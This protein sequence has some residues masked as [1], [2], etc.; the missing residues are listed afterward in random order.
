VIAP[1]AVVPGGRGNT[2]FAPRV[3]SACLSPA[4]SLFDLAYATLRAN[5]VGA[6]AEENPFVLSLSKRETPTP[7]KHLHPQLA[8]EFLGLRFFPC[9][10]RAQCQPHRLYWRLRYLNS[11]NLSPRSYTDH[12]FPQL[13]R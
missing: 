9:S 4:R 7:G 5:G 1:P 12:L 8:L 6:R 2:R 11:L 10:H 3:V 13:Q